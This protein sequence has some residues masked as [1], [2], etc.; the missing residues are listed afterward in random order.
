MNSVSKNK[1]HFLNSFINV[2]ILFQGFYSIFPKLLNN[3]IRFADN[4]FTYSHFNF[5]SIVEI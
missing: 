2:L 3:I 4:G 5:N 1:N